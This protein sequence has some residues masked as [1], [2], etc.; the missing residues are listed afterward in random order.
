VNRSIGTHS[1]QGVVAVGLA[2]VA[3]LL[4][5]A[6]P[7]RAATYPAGGSGFSGG[8]EGWRV[9]DAGCDPAA[10]CSASGGYDGGNGAP[11]G[12]LT[13]DT[14]VGLNLLT[15]FDST[16]T[17]QSPDFTVA[18]GGA[19]TLHL[20][21]QF[22]PGNQVDLA[23]ESTYTV[24]LIDRTADRESEAISETID[25]AS[26]FVGRD[27][28]VSVV[29]GHTYAISIETEISSSVAGTGLL[30][31]T[32]STRFDNVSL[33]VGGGAGG[34]GGG[35]D[36]RLSNRRLLSTIQGN[37]VAP[38]TLKGKRL[39]VK[40]RCPAAVGHTCRVTLQGL[41]K[42]RRAATR[43]R[44]VRIAKGKAKR[45]VLVV[46]PAAQKKVAPRKRL[47]FKQTVVAGPARATVYKSLKL[48]R[49]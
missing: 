24:T 25:A 4:L 39:F 28:A 21:R 36:N 43:K 18:G 11:P 1:G 10:F 22:A 14:N 44:V 16:V 34:S 32:T 20:D 8:A 33:S 3:M 23:P 41:L 49:R 15:L 35:D 45:I 19:G 31:G 27:A 37:L 17:L 26:G 6:G 7:A 46:K 12:S 47:L 9:T 48:I 2:T 13:A 40:A 38:A 5:V 29:P 30:A 42:K